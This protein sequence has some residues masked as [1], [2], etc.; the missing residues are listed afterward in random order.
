MGLWSTIATL[1][2]RKVN[3]IDENIQ[4]ANAIPLMTQQ[5]ADA[6][7]ALQKT[8]DDN[9]DL[10]ASYKMAAKELKDVQEEIAKYTGHVK[11]VIETQGRESELVPQIL[12]K[13]RGLKEQEA[14]KESL[15]NTYKTNAEK[16]Q[17][18]IDAGQA[19]I[20]QLES[21]LKTLKAQVQANEARKAMSTSSAFDDSAMSDAMASADRLKQRLAKD[22]ARFE[23]EAEM[24]GTKK[25][26]LDS[27][28][29]D[30]GIGGTSK[31]DDDLLKE[32][33]I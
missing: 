27:Q 12:D 18:S 15:A 32:L 31:N 5:I 19:K 25:G 7:K 11:K 26:S 24:E 1:G 14:S 21:T 33:G 2:K 22:D 20:Q 6:K 9:V 17:R 23:A 4:D 28:L 13:I 29:A 10:L 3:E 30:L 16:V 8:R